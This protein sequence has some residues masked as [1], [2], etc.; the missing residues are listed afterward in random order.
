MH[1]V[2]HLGDGA[3]AEH[4]AGNV[5][6]GYVHGDVIRGAVDLIHGGG[7]LDGAAER[8]GAFHADEGVV[9]DDVHAQA[10]RGGVGHDGADGA[11]TDHAQRLSADFGTGELGL[12]LF[13]QLGNL[14][15]LS[16]QSARPVDAAGHVTAAQHQAADD[17]L[18]HGVGVGAGGVE[19][20]DA[21]PGALVDGD[22]VG[23]RARARDGQQAV[24]Q[25]HVMHG[26]R[27]N[28]NAVRHGLLL[29]N[30][31]ALGGQA[32]M[33]D[34]GNIVERLNLIHHAF[35]FSKAFITST[36]FFT[37]STGMAL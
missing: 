29:G 18:G 12:A 9:T 19:N 32:L 3:F 31:I 13:D 27:A 6:E 11:Q 15:A 14:R 35:S 30:E 34:V 37:P 17:Q 20:H 5:G 22:V 7:T 36:S 26:G 25:V 4:A 23:T 21:A 24:G 2:F 8:P 10:L 1:A 28:Q 16:V 33:D